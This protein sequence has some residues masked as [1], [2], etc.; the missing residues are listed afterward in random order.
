LIIVAE[1]GNGCSRLIE[2]EGG[3]E[4]TF[5]NFVGLLFVHIITNPA[6]SRR[7]YDLV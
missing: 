5:L 7:A 1:S 2:R 4:Q 6:F 3:I